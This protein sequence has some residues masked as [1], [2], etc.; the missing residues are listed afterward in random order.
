MQ[1]VM[2]ERFEAQDERGDL[3]AEK[4]RAGKKNFRNK[5]RGCDE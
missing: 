4:K 1:R 3:G 2:V 5:K